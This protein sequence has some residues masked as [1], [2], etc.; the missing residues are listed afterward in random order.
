[1]IMSSVDSTLNSSSTLVVVDF[2]QET[3]K[4]IPERIHQFSQQFNSEQFPFKFISN[5]IF[6]YIAH[7]A[8]DR[9]ENI[10]LNKAKPGQDIPDIYYAVYQNII[11]ISLFNHEA[12]LFSHIYE[13]EHN[14]EKI[15]MLLNAK[16]SSHFSFEKV[17]DKSS[18]LTDE[19]FIDFVK[20]GKEHCFR[21]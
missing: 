5:G 21:G 13:G 3:S 14:L 17:G 18:N 7:E 8:V 6:G 12:H 1:A 9:F 10:T 4:D 2:I 19:Q 15:E 11:A 20:K 16:N